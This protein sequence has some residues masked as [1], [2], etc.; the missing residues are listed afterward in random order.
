MKIFKDLEFE[1]IFTGRKIE[2]IPVVKDEKKLC[3]ILATVMELGLFL[4]MVVIQM[5][6]TL[7]K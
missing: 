1:S 4:G 2:F 6:T 7:M 5:K 3:Y